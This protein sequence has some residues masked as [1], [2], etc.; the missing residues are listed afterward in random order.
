MPPLVKQRIAAQHCPRY[1]Q[2][3]L[4]HVGPL[5]NLQKDA[6]TARGESNPRG[7]FFAW[8]VTLLH[9]SNNLREDEGRATPELSQPIRIQGETPGTELTSNVAK[10][11]K[12]DGSA[13]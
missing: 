13:N 4:I 11:G 12:P 3:G 5:P 2:H 10:G 7:L 9:G 1:F 8:R 6:G